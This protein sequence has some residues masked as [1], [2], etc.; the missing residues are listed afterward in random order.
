[1]INALI[2]AAVLLLTTVC[3]GDGLGLDNLVQCALDRS[4]L[5][6]I[7]HDA[8]RENMRLRHQATDLR[9]KLV[10]LSEQL[11][12][13]GD[14]HSALLRQHTAVTQGHQELL[15]AQQTREEEHSALHADF[16]GHLQRLQNDYRELLNEKTK[17]QDDYEGRLLETDTTISS[18]R[19]QI[20]ENDQR[21]QRQTSHFEESLTSYKIE[22][23]RALEEKQTIQT[24]FQT[25]LSMAVDTKKKIKAVEEKLREVL[26]E[27]NKLEEKLKKAEKDREAAAEENTKTRNK[28]SE[29]MEEAEEERK[30]LLNEKIKMKEDYEGRLNEAEKTV[31]SLRREMKDKEDRFEQLSS[32]FE[33]GLTSYKVELIRALDEK[34]TI[35]QHFETRLQM[36]VDIKKKISAAEERLRAAFE[37]RNKMEEKLKRA[38]K[39]RDA[40]VEE[41]RKTREYYEG[42]VYVATLTIDRLNAELKARRNEP[43]ALTVA[44]G[45]APGREEEHNA[46]GCQDDMQAL[47]P[48]SA[49]Q[50][51]APVREEGDK[52]FSTD[53]D[54]TDAAE[55]SFD[56][57]LH[58]LESM[59]QERGDNEPVSVS[60]E[61][62]TAEDGDFETITKKILEITDSYEASAFF[63]SQQREVLY[64]AD[65]LIEAANQQENSLYQIENEDNTTDQEEDKAE[66]PVEEM[67]ER[68][69][70]GR[71]EDHVEKFQQKLKSDAEDF[72]AVMEEIMRI[73]EHYSQL[74]LSNT[75]EHE[76]LPQSAE[77]ISYTKNDGEN[78]IDYDEGDQNVAA[79]NKEK[80]KKTSENTENVTSE[81]NEQDP[82]G[83]TET[84]PEDVEEFV[85]SHEADDQSFHRVLREISQTFSFEERI[86]C[87]ANTEQATTE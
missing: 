78:V 84:V 38:E 34:Q 27:R 28:L 83:L 15:A 50:G 72:D 9:K 45:V 13:L 33:K 53:V 62:N 4:Q 48:L 55:K 10:G 30:M 80:S 77:D 26:E 7:S 23:I 41:N 14:D 8:H 43:S 2:T 85:R 68:R 61:E 1:M 57:V 24:H 21:F 20:V 36:A 19:R 76:N 22:L 73:S 46:E 71:D 74:V 6:E 70:E 79:E 3:C 42:S 32:H 69:G 60:E 52:I 5:L 44:G 63:Y 35:Q 87:A 75:Q 11:L 56:E 39:D 86:P 59:I 18:L 47:A 64:Q 25:R 37:E 16:N 81:N 12:A 67:E 51:E 65:V 54:D 66:K 17:I 31:S 40:A 58:V 49:V 29:K 82:H